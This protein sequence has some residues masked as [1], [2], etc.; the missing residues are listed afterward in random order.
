MGEPDRTATE[1][2]MNTR[3]FRLI[4]GGK[5]RILLYPTGATMAVSGCAH[6][7]QGVRRWI[8]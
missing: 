5:G 7:N 8:Y 3:K 6:P 1:T 4:E 2:T